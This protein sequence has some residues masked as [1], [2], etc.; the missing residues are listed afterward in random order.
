MSTLYEQGESVAKKV[1][2]KSTRC[3]TYA[4]VADESD[5]IAKAF[6][7]MLDYVTANANESIIKVDEVNLTVTVSGGNEY[8]LC[9]EVVDDKKNLKKPCNIIRYVSLKIYT[10]DSLYIDENNEVIDVTHRGIN[11]L[12]NNCVGFVQGFNETVGRYP[13]IIPEILLNWLGYG[14]N[15]ISSDISRNISEIPESTPCFDTTTASAK[16]LLDYKIAFRLMNNLSDRSMTY[17]YLTK[18]CGLTFNCSFN[19]STEPLPKPKNYSKQKSP[20][21][22][23]R[24][25]RSRSLMDSIKYGAGGAT[26]IV[27]ALQQM[28]SV[29]YMGYETYREPYTDINN[30]LATVSKTALSPEQANQMRKDLEAIIVLNKKI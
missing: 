7:E 24:Y 19:P 26:K 30:D 29:S 13:N 18:R 6:G 16:N 23:I 12:S 25:A 17:N 10:K 21:D 1:L 11:D 22:D 9:H 15:D 2:R 20:A 28:D 8:S 5:N 3:K 4:Y 27:D 14:T